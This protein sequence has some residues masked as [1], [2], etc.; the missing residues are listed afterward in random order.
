MGTKRVGHGFNIAWRPNLLQTLKDNDVCIECC[1]ISNL[2]LGYSLDLRNHPARGF[3]H[4]GIPVAIS[5]D[6]PGF[7]RYHGVTLD[8]VYAF[9]AWDL[10][11]ADLKKL[12]FNSIKY[13]SLTQ[14]EKEKL[15]NFFVYKWKRFLDF[16]IG[17]F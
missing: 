5:S 7:M 10:N 17:K 11:I 4:A 12:C 3:L 6:D 8:Y 1:P 13:S 14:E 15:A 9:L 16:V 2:V